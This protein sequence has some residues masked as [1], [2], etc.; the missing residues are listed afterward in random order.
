MSHFQ[1]DIVAYEIPAWQLGLII[2]AIVLTGVVVAFVV[3]RR[4][5]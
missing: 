3:T 1:I 4:K 2:G 5:K